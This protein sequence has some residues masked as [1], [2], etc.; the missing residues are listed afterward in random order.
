MAF[1]VAVTSIVLNIAGILGG[2]TYINLI[3]EQNEVRMISLLIIQVLIFY[4]TRIYLYNKDVDVGEVSWD[5]WLMNIII[6]IISIVVL[7][8]ILEISTN[9]TENFRNKGVQ[10]AVF[11]SMGI[12]LR[13]EERRVGKE[14]L[15]LCRSR[16]SPYH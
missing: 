3:K 12:F 7:A 11:A 14:C 5:I 6:P 15:R 10:M 9:T 1:I 8:F 4:I 16:W 2:Y 13:S